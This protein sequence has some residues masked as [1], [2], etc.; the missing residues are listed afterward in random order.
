M[1]ARFQVEAGTAQPEALEA[2]PL[3]PGLNSKGTTLVFN[4]TGTP[5][6]LLL[7]PHCPQLRSVLQHGLVRAVGCFAALM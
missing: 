1:V 6:L 3:S 5:S 7:K 2:M 4:I